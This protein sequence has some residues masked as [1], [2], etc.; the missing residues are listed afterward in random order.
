MAV[1]AGHVSI[2]VWF[3]FTGLGQGSVLRRWEE[4]GSLGKADGLIFHERRGSGTWRAG[5]VVSYIPKYPR[6]DGIGS[7]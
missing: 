4:M 7:S 2:V 1:F 3:A 6:A 5:K